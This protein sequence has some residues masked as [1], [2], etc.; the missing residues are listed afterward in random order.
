MVALCRPDL[1]PPQYL[2][3][4]EKLQDQIPPF[5]TDLALSV[6]Q[7]EYGTPAAAV[8]ADLSPQPLAAAS[9]GQVWAVGG[10]KLCR[11]KGVGREHVVGFMVLHKLFLQNKSCKGRNG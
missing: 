11:L 6:I 3:E 2:R 8:F 1:V 4:L 10:R 7:E 5:S 9:L